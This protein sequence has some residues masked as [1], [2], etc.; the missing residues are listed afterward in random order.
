MPNAH[1]LLSPRMRIVWSYGF[2]ISLYYFST[3]NNPS[4]QYLNALEEIIIRKTI[5]SYIDDHAF[6]ALPKLKSLFLKELNLTMK[7]I[8]QLAF[9]DLQIEHLDL[10]S[11]N[12]RSIHN[13]MFIG[14]KNLKVLDLSR[15]MI[16]H[17]QNQAF[18]S[19]LQLSMLNLDHNNLRTVT[20]YW[21][22]AFTHYSSLQV[23]LV[24]NS[25][26]NECR[27]RGMELAENQWF[28]RSI[29]PNSSLIIDESPV[30]I[31][32]MPT[33]KEFY[34][35]I[36]VKESVSV[37]LACSAN[38]IPKPTL[39]WLIP[40][41]LEVTSSILPF[42]INNGNLSITKVRPGISG[43]YACIATN[44]EGAS[45][46][47]TKLSVI[48]NTTTTSTG[49]MTTPTGMK[50]ASLTLLIIFIIILSLALCIVLVYLSRF[51]FKWVKRK[52]NNTDFEFSRFVDTPNILPVPENPQP[53]PH[54]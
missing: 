49:Q 17:I 22:K 42:S 35:E 8:H 54:L 9:N 11:N 37:T 31:C 27:F 50:R 20:P 43:L 39:S 13:K 53:M 1:V 5:V 30:P 25:F 16:S 7:N 3:I 6:N 44:S 32:T 45:V 18:E 15:N 34:Q 29:T 46:S 26:T 51:I 2:H 48:S 19:L 40:T 4:F 41:G 36:Y 14:L 23:S 21:F 52:K 33:F 12:L 10:S 47:L 28:L 38:G 24:G